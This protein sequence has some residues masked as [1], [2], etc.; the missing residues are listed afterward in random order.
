MGKG[1]GKGREEWGVGRGGEGGIVAER[2]RRGG[3]SGKEW[4]GCEVN[5]KHNIK[6]K[7]KFA[8]GEPPT[9]T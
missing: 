4:E 5:S 9:P 7:L 8:N 3:V 2:S 6:R 1:V